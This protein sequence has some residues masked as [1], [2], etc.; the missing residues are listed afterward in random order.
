M[1]EMNTI[2][3][4]AQREVVEDYLL[5]HQIVTDASLR[6]KV[7]PLPLAA[8]PFHF[9]PSMA[10]RWPYY[11]QNSILS[12]KRVKDFALSPHSPLADAGNCAGLH[13]HFE[14]ETLP[15]FLIFSNELV[16]KH[17]MGLMLTPMIAFSASPYFY[18]EHS[19]HSMRA[20]R[21]Y[22]GVYEKFPLN[23][24]LP[25]VM[26]TSEEVLRYTLSGIE[27]W[28][29]KATRIGFAREDVYKL[30]AKKGANWSMIRWNRTWNTIELRCLESDRV[31]YDISKFIWVAGAMKRL[32]L[33]GEAL[34]PQP[35]STRVKLDEK[36]IEESLVV[37]GKTVS[38]L[39]TVAIHEL[40]VRAVQNGLQDALVEKYLHRL[41]EFAEKGVDEDCL[42]VFAILKR[43]LEKKL[44]TADVVLQALNNASKITQPECAPVIRDLL[45]QERLA[46]SQL[47]AEFPGVI[48]KSR[49]E[50]FPSF[51]PAP[52]TSG[53]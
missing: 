16:H 4:T 52:K 2:A 31:D 11:V 18:E 45:Q 25:P 23:G 8:V 51:V 3:S 21:Y 6:E 10:P 30:T 22:F 15:E 9:T 43:A 29:D 26:Q 19:A 39:P 38:I 27:S 41:A 46:V 40:T 5:L 47:R 35:L 49:S 48:P 13:A 1:V 37:S 12:G 14:I 20:K 28:L 17:N 24:G 44:T 42:K 53:N 36:M 32:D 34:Q 50:L 33:K 7:V